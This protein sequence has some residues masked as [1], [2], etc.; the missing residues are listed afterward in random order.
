MKSKMKVTCR[1]CKEKDNWEIEAPDGTVLK[2]HY[3]TREECL[4][5]GL[6]YAEECGCDMCICTLEKKKEK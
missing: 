5:A 4:K 6:K 1:P 3:S 2:K